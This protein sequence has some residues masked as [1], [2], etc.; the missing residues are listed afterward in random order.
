MGTPALRGPSI[1]KAFVIAAVCSVT[2]ACAAT[3]MP[4]MSVSQANSELS[5]GYM[6]DAGDQ[7]KVTVFDEESLT[8]EYEVGIGGTL[9]LPLIEPVEVRNRQPVE[10]AQLIEQQLLQ[11]GYVLDPRVSVEILEHRSFFILGEVAA[12]GEY[13]HNGELTLEQAVA[14][15]GGY[16]ARADKAQIVLKRQSWT[17]SRI[18]K[19]GQRTLQIAPGDTITIRESFF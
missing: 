10:V 14:K 19:L 13:S 3:G 5:S 7:L 4:S 1:F 6:I 15:A 8:G 18:I 16:S 12:P 2:A 11:G 9:A 17:E